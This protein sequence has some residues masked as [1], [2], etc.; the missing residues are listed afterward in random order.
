MTLHAPSRTSTKE[1]RIV[2][3][4]VAAFCV[5]M[6]LLIWASSEN[7]A[8]VYAPLAISVLLSLG[9][10]V[11]EAC[12]GREWAIGLYFGILV[13][14]V[15]ISLRTREIGPVALDWQS[16]LK[17][18][19][20][21]IALVIGL[22][23]LTRARLPL[24]AAHNRLFLLYALLALASTI[25]SISPIYTLGSA[26]G[27][28]G[29]FL[30][31][32]AAAQA[33]SMR[34]IALITVVSLGA[35]L[36]VSWIVDLS[37]PGFNRATS[38]SIYGTVERMGG[39]AAHPNQLA[40]STAIFAVFAVILHRNRHLHWSLCLAAL[41]LAAATLWA[42]DS[43]TSAVAALAAY[44]FI[45]L[46]RSLWLV[47]AAGAL[48]ILGAV[49]LVVL[50]SNALAE[51]LAPLSRSGDVAEILSLTGRIELWKFV[52]QK[53]MESPFIGHGF[54]A[55]E[56]FLSRSYPHFPLDWDPQDSH[57]MILQTLLTLGLLGVVLLGFVLW[58]LAALYVRSPSPYRDA[59]LGLVL[60]TGVTGSGAFS[61]TPSLLT[62]MML[63]T[64]AGTETR[65]AASATSRPASPEPSADG[66]FEG[67]R[68][69]G[70][71]HR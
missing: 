56:P 54:N 11:F 52:W 53:S 18:L 8:F 26:L 6:G 44:G 68:L 7:D 34:Q 28:L 60:M 58:R 42:T 15:N 1:W 16:G 37:F 64:M 50:P 62:L 55:S 38:W 59:M 67:H 12:R 40:K 43:R 2:V 46:R 70:K 19:V 9:W 10:V 41:L 27:L 45:V 13:F 21:S 20:W 65:E 3:P 31:S 47:A 35:F 14:M 48:L 49:V 17:F 36:L 61:V 25:Y 63:V 22:C 51:L 57:N 66:R 5:V 39:I 33:L 30:F 32:I 24:A 29:L 71:I 23:C 69:R 4:S